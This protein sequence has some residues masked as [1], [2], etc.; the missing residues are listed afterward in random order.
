MCTH[1]R[2]HV[3][4]PRT[5]T[6]ACRLRPCCGCPARVPSPASL[7][8]SMSSTSDADRSPCPLLGPQG[9]EGEDVE[10]REEKVCAVCGDRATGYHFHVMTC[11]GCK[12]FFR[13][14]LPPRGDPRLLCS[15]G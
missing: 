11:E 8:T 6:L 14:G 1:M 2:V 15:T 9:P 10:P 12:G 13:W 3:L 7:A 5:L 4:T